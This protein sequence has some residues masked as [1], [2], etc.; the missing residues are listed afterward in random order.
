METEKTTSINALIEINNDRYEGY[1]TSAQETND[2]DLKTLFTGFSEQSRGFAN[3][4][5]KYVS[6]DEVK[7]GETTNS[8]K[9]FRVWM[10]IK[11]TLTGKDRKAILSSCEFGEDAAKKTYDEILRKCEDLSVGA[12]ATIQGQRTEIQKGHDTIKSMRD[13]LK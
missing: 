13:S 11:A 3:D 8:G 1:K 12:I 7:T 5:K 10:D 2:A 9:L 4:L 6:A